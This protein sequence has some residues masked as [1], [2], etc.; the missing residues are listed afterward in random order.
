M[1]LLAGAGTNVNTT[2][3]LSSNTEYFPCLDVIV[4]ADKVTTAFC[5]D[6]APLI[7]GLVGLVGG[8]GVF[9]LV[10]ATVCEVLAGAI[11]KAEVLVVNFD[12]SLWDAGVLM[13]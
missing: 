1:P 6:F 2:G 11:F 13:L 12:T 10:D 9:I 5:V 8:V 4:V 3:G 7:A